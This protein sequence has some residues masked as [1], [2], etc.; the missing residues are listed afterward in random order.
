MRNNS[1]V[2]KTPNE[3]YSIIVVVKVSAEIPIP[4]L[5]SVC[6]KKKNETHFSDSQS[7]LYGGQCS[8]IPYVD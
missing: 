2:Q 6:G 7:M 4:D 3:L 5:I 1:V 8:E